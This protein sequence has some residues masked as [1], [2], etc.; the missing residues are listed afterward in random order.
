MIYDLIINATKMV[1]EANDLIEK[2]RSLIC[3]VS[4]LQYKLESEVNR[5][6]ILLE[7][8]NYKIKYISNSL[9][10]VFSVNYISPTSQINRITDEL[11]RNNFNG[12]IVFDCLLNNGLGSQR[13]FEV[14]FDSKFNKINHIS[15][16]LLNKVNS[17]LNQFYIDNNQLLENSILLDSDKMTIK[18]NKFISLED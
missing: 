18:E 13:L 2:D 14:I 16:E 3:N 17:I 11:N 15:E 9:A 7:E 4:E 6:K 1:K 10:I 12:V 5:L 8:N